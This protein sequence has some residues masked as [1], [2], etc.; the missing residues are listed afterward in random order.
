MRDHDF[1]PYTDLPELCVA[2]LDDGDT[3]NQPFD[4]H[5]IGS[6]STQTLLEQYR[7]D[8]L[9]GDTCLEELH[10]RAMN[11]DVAAREVLNDHDRDDPDW[12]PQTG[13]EA[14]P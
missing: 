6:Q 8:D 4:Q 10:E 12:T 5:A 9:V 7:R 2:E 13:S 11:G 14:Q 1:K 3:C